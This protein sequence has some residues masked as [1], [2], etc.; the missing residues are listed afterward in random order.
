V[1]TGLAVGD[2][3]DFA[4][5]PLVATLATHRRDGSILLSPVWFEW[6]DGFVFITGADD[7]KIRHMRR[8][9]RASMSV[10]EN[11]PPYRGIEVS[12]TPELMVAA[13]EAPLTLERIAA[14]YLGKDRGQRYAADSKP[15]ELAVV[16]LAPGRLR[17]WDFADESY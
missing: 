12:G 7:V 1:R 8:D 9:P 17:V 6:Q 4:Q 13:A 15:E 2:L 16:R 5:Q 14:R 10:A 3:G 11:E